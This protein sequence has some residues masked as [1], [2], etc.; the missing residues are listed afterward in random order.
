M[1]TFDWSINI[2]NVLT[3][4][5]LLTVFVTAHA[6]NVKRLQD[7]ETKLDLIFHWFRNNV[8]NRQEREDS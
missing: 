6:A 2:G 1:F 5:G 7:M 8:I 3:V 4:V